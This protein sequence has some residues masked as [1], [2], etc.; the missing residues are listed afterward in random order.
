MDEF[1]GRCSHAL[2]DNGRVWAIDA[3][4]GVGVEERIRSAGEPAGVVQ[5]LDRHNRD[6][7]A[8]AERLGVEHHAVPHSIPDSPFEFLVVR[9]GR[10]WNEVALWWPERRVLACADALGTARYYRARGEQLAV[11]PLLRFLPP[12]RQLAGVCPQRI[13]CG[14]GEG[15]HDGAETELR[16][17]LRTA[18]GLI[19]AQVAASARAWLRAR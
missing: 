17:A 15:I 13:L 7:G 10:F 18:R 14:H 9:D 1:L 12:R 16:E 19:P 4:A 8:L 11:H 2:V 3:V 6:C 5:L